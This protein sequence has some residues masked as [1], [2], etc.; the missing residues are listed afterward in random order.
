[1]DQQEFD[2]TWFIVWL[3]RKV[4]NWCHRAYYHVDVATVKPPIGIV[5][6]CDVC[7]G[8][9]FKAQHYMHMN[10]DYFASS[11]IRFPYELKKIF[12]WILHK[13]HYL[14]KVHSRH[15]TLHLDQ[16][17]RT[18]EYSFIQNS[19]YSFPVTNVEL[20]YMLDTL[21]FLWLHHDS[22]PYLLY[23]LEKLINGLS[24]ECTSPL[25]L[26]STTTTLRSCDWYQSIIQHGTINCYR[27]VQWEF[28][29]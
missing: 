20:K 25:P 2:R 16:L 21:G 5:S 10:G 13:L 18:F 4:R 7:G 19:S 3:K 9:V 11:T 6:N 14:D 28:Q 1:M 26:C 15:F 22:S 27:C 8:L 17:D 24:D 23:L 29:K 12:D